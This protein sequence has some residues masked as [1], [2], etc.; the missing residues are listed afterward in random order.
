MYC[1]KCGDALKE[2]NG[3]FRCVR[4]DM[5][6][7]RYMATHLYACFVSKSEQPEDFRFKDARYHFGGHWFCLGCGVSMREETPVAVRCPNCERNI[8]KFLHQ[9]VEL[10]P[11]RAVP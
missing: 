6:L 8:G 2:T 11:H 3:A 4:G 5:D 9:L 7:S 1:P 10:H